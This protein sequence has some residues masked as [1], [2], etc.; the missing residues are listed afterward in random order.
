[1]YL[2]IYRQGLSILRSATTRRFIYILALALLLTGVFA[3]QQI[4]RD[5][6]WL[7]IIDDVKI[8]YQI[9][10][11]P[12]WQN[13]TLYGFPKNESGNVVA[14]NTYERVAWATAGIKS[15]PNHPYGVGI[16]ILPLG[17][18]AQELF[19]G[20]R[21]ISTHSGWI[22][23]TLAFGIPFICLMW[24]AN[25]SIAYQAIKQQ[26]PFKY[27][28]ITLSIILFGLFLVGELSNG[29]NLEMLFYLFALMAGMQIDQKIASLTHSEP[30]AQ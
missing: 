26:S 11:Y 23:L 9:E 14:Y 13:G 30:F 20:V 7:Q 21:P 27:T 15:I 6:G 12:H 3:Y 29:H 16:L 10:K 8:G 22:D 5:A 1:M 2:F 4:Q 25:A 17:L 28:L 19:P 18:A 24:L